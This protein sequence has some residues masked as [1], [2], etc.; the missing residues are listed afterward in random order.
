[1]I[2]LRIEPY[3]ANEHLD[4][5]LE[6]QFPSTDFINSIDWDQSAKNIYGSGDNRRQQRS[7]I[8]ESNSLKQDGGIK[9]Y[10]I[11]SCKLLKYLQQDA[12]Y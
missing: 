1:M 2:K 6:K 3:L 7:I 9:H 4:T 5:G 8:L 11:N 12:N 10:G